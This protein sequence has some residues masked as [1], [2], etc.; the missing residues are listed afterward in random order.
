MRLSESVQELQ[1]LTTY[2]RDLLMSVQGQGE[3][4]V[5]VTE[6]SFMATHSSLAFLTEREAQVIDRMLEGASSIVI[7]NANPM[8]RYWRD[9]IRSACTR[10]ET[11]PSRSSTSVEV[12]SGCRLSS[13]L[14]GVQ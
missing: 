2:Y 3:L 6:Q 10:A 12:C 13:D 9:G 11:L 4:R 7:P 5:R 14:V 1:S 8:Q